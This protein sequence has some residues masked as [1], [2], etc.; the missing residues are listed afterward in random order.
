MPLVQNRITALICPSRSL[1]T[2]DAHVAQQWPVL[3][4]I[5]A[6][7]VHKVTELPE[8]ALGSQELL[9][10]LQNLMQYHSCNDQ[11]QLGFAWPDADCIPVS[12][13]P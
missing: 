13:V 2:L 5:A 12:E 3:L 7:I 9:L 8:Q 6:H 1:L 4:S 10:H 11:Q